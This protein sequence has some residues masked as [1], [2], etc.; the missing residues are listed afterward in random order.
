MIVAVS[1]RGLMKWLNSEFNIWK[2]GKSLLHR[3][4]DFQSA[5]RGKSKCYLFCHLNFASSCSYDR[6]GM[7]CIGVTGLWQRDQIP[8]CLIGQ[9]LVNLSNV[10]VVL[11][12]N[13]AVWLGSVF[14]LFCRGNLQSFIHE[15][16]S[17]N[18][19]IGLTI[20]IHV[21]AVITR[22]PPCRISQSIF[23]CA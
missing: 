22:L 8:C 2:Q 18:I 15:S 11:H 5:N 9:N 21:S 16:P 3:S 1:G 4:V 6:A 13:T 19:E 10:W 12:I 20:I 14:A 7:I 23:C 17:F